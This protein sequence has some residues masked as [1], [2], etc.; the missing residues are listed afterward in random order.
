M[1][2]DIV[3]C[4]SQL[5][6]FFRLFDCIKWSSIVWIAWTRVA[7]WSFTNLIV[8]SNDIIFLSL[9]VKLPLYPRSTALSNPACSLRL[10]A[11]SLPL[12][13]RFVEPWSLKL[14][15]IDF[16]P[17]AKFFPGIT[18][19]LELSCDG[20]Q[21]RPR[22]VW[23]FYCEFFHKLASIA[24]GNTIIGFNLFWSTRYHSPSRSTAAIWF[25]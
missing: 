11:W 17:R 22:G 1:I 4:F 24:F 20:Q 7:R 9:I 12:A 5:Q 25:E 2:Q 13:P 8:L 3:Q 16:D 18:H 21:L 23:Y 10:G 19:D 14:V 6:N 15:A